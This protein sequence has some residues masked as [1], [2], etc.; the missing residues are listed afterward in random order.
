MNTSERVKTLREHLNLSQSKFANSIGITQSKIA[1]IEVGKGRLTPEI[2]KKIEDE[3]KSNIRWLF[4]G[5]GKM[6]LSEENSDNEKIKIPIDYENSGSCGCGICI[7]DNHC[8]QYTY[9]S[10]FWIKNILK[11]ST[12]DLMIIF[13]TGDSMEDT[14]QDRDMLLVDKNQN[15]PKNGI[16]LVR[17]YNQLL[18]KRI[19]ILPFETRLISD[20]RKYDY[21][22][23]SNSELNTLEIIGKV[24]WNG[25]KKTL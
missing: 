23:V 21:I 15:E 1:D 11:V 25:S 8:P 4:F 24:V 6:F 12:Q 17:L 5:E 10:K 20:N 14:I 3:Y 19:N 22:P 18:V 16:Y 2:A 13:A 9:L 7:N